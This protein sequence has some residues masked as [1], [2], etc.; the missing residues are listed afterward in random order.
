MEHNKAPGPGVFS[1]K[2][3]QVSWEVIKDDLMALFKEFHRG[4]VTPRF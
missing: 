4:N 1:V 2:F 3:Y